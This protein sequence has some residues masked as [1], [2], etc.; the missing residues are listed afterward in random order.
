[1]IVT[2]NFKDLTGRVFDQLTVI[3]RTE[4]YIQPN[5]KRKVQWLCF[6]ECGN[7]TVVRGDV[8][9]NNKT[10]SCGCLIRKKRTPPKEE[11]KTKYPIYDLSGEFGIGWT[12]DGERFLFDLEDYDLISKYTWCKDKRYFYAKVKGTNKRI[13]LHRLIMGFPENMEVD[14]R[15]GKGSEFDNRKSNLRVATHIENCQ[16]KSRPSN[17]T[18]GHKGV[19]WDKTKQKWA[20]QIGYHNKRITLGR[21]DNI[22]DAIECRNNAER[23][24][25]GEF[26]NIE[27]DKEKDDSD[28]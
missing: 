15:H 4:D 19:S 10:K 7:Y 26:A 3:C 12:S 8:L 13:A 6:C 17:N 16:N 21:F 24:L 5:G 20:A 14:H 2:K 1:M 25:F 18:S 9:R 22:E 27:E 23:K 11:D 28:K